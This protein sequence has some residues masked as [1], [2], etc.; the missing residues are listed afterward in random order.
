[1]EE[2]NTTKV[3]KY[4]PARPLAL[5]PPCREDG[6]LVTKKWATD[7]HWVLP[8]SA[9]K[10][11]IK[12]NPPK[13]RLKHLKLTNKK[14]QEIVSDLGLV[15]TR[16]SIPDLIYTNSPFEG[17]P[18]LVFFIGI[19]RFGINQ[20]L[21]DWITYRLKLAIGPP[22]TA[23]SPIPILDANNKVIGAV[24]PITLPLA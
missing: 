14:V 4:E 24:M 7:G 19:D 16:L 5:R 13:G 22:N 12:G 8:L 23:T 6:V 20:K 18:A 11:L 9:H 10:S 3:I 21:Y 1:M 17:T 15:A 2:K